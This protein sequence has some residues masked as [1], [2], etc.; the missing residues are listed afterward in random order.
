MNNM[1]IDFNPKR[2]ANLLKTMVNQKCVAGFTWYED[3]GDMPNMFDI[4][5]VIEILENMESS[6]VTIT[7]D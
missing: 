2:V 4:C 6:S 3:I 5:K 1:T 7:N